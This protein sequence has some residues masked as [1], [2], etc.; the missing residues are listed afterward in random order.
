MDAPD[1]INVEKKDRNLY[2]KLK[3][4]DVFKDV[5]RKEQFLIAM[6]YGFRSGTKKALGRPKDGF[7]LAKDMN[8]EDEALLAAVA[9]HD[10]NDPDILV[11][12]RKVYEI[13][14]EYAHAGIRILHSKLEGAQYGSL[15]KRLERDMVEAYEGLFCGKGKHVR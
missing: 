3:E 12:K 15:S 9:L 8:A 2:D 10:Q 6:A 4:E 11:D 13:A 5:S 1:R 7:F 14:E